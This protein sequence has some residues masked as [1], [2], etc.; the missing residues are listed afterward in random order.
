MGTATIKAPGS[1]PPSRRRMA[2]G[3]VATGQTSTFN[4]DARS[5]R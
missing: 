5:F 2:L 3:T 4:H 1:V